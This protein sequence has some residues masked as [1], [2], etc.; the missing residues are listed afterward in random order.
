MTTPTTPK[1]EYCDKRGLPLLL[2]R[3][4]VAPVGAGAPLD[5]DPEIRL[6]ILAAHYSKRLIRTGYVNVHDEARKRWE[7]YFV[8]PEGYFFKLLQ[9]PGVTPVLPA[10]PFNCPDQGHRA[11]ASCITVS[12][13]KNATK[14]WIGF[15][16]VL[17]TEAVRKAHES[18]AYR[19]RHMVEVDVQAV[20]AGGEVPHTRPIAQVPAVVA[21]YALDEKKGQVAFG[22][23]PFKFN[24]RHGQAERLLSECETMRP[25]KGLIV[26]LADPT[27][28]AQELA[29]LMQW[30]TNLFMSKNNRR[31]HLA[32]S[33]AISSIRQGVNNQSKLNELSAAEQ[34]ANEQ[35]SAN[36]LGHMFSES[37]RT[38]TEELRNVTPAELDR[39]VVHGWKKYAEKFNDTARE[40]W[41]K[42]F[43]AE[44]AAYDE[45]HIAPL[46]RNHVNWM[47][48]Q[49]M[50]DHL[51][52]NYDRKN[53]ESGAVYTAVV[54]HC[55]F[56][57]QD[58]AAC[59]KLYDTWLE[60]DIA[61]KKNILL[62]AMVFNQDAI[63]KEVKNS[64]TVN[65]DIRQIPWDNL[66][67]T[68]TSAVGWLKEDA[69]AAAARL[70]VQLAGPV[71]R[72]LG[73]IMDG[74]A[75]FRAAVMATGLISGHPV[76]VCEVEGGRKVFR[77][78]LIRELIRS[79]GQVLDQNQ[80]RRAVAA[81]LRLQQINGVQMEGN[82]RKRWLV[83][84]DAK[85]IRDMPPGLSPRQRAEWLAKSIRT[86]QAVETLNLDRWRTVINA[87]VRFGVVAGLLQAASLTKL[88]A[89]E[90]KA[91]ANESV[92]AQYR[93]YAGMG[94]V[95][96]T[97]AEILGNAMAGRIKLGMRFGQGLAEYSGSF[98][99]IGGKAAGVGA[100]LFVAY[101]DLKKAHS[102]Y[103][104]NA[105]GWLVG[106]YLGAAV[107]GVSLGLSIVFAA[108]LG[109]LA[110]PVIG[111]LVLL[112]IGIGILIEYIKD[113]PV[114][115]WLERCPWGIL[116]DQRYPDLTTEQAQLQQALK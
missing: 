64:T 72:M 112:A 29:L 102:E 18:A 32:A 21:E 42:K 47:K 20:L 37:T 22:W 108:S 54:T 12:D 86:V 84:A 36:P 59:G 23:S 76:V 49:A 39:A 55:I 51:E 65:I 71:A 106:A 1:C 107:V 113:N 19:K 69:Q 105:S 17:W 109:A 2:V 57:T 67:A 43:N 61:E 114:Q 41:V 87:D 82:T 27:G 46:A 85:A 5:A 31:R 83:L 26:T 58:K 80:M 56:G 34:L 8:T 48:S 103:R 110:I 94:A 111:V 89:D 13:P 16:D 81:E 73:K 63:A 60:G 100:A 52:C 10:K 25:G 30:N 40:A 66:F 92:D 104:E 11:I 7:T 88:F 33:A 15:S 14:V 79:S 95:A 91:L 24:A 78:H 4:G 28:I 115:D 90:E 44:L 50:A 116:P 93:L 38:Q 97:T 101:L 45:I 74:S 3:D 35:V 99:R 77:A 9:T 96:G 98:L 53:A 68:Y 75:G 70:I 62:Q 6:S